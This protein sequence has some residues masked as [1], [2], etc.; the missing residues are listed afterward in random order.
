MPTARSPA[1]RVA[2]KTT[3]QRVVAAA[4]APG[5]EAWRG[6]FGG[7]APAPA[8]PPIDSV[9]LVVMALERLGPASF[10]GTMLGKPVDVVVPDLATAAVFRA[11]LEHTR[12]QRATDRLLNIV[13]KGPDK[14]H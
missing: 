7:R 11:A 12:L 13:V 8:A 6:W 10:R 5:P 9:G 2:F 14:E 1:L 4:R 3:F